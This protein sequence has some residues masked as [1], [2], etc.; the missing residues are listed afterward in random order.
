MDILPCYKRWGKCTRFLY[1]KYII[2]VK[3]S[4][5][6]CNNKFERIAPIE[7]G[8]I[9][10]STNTPEYGNS[11]AGTGVTI[12]L[13]NLS[14]G[15]TIHDLFVYIYYIYGYVEQCFESKTF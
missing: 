3:I 2:S 4:A 11:E 14:G 13:W 15:I 9:E 1:C 10:L 12:D 8:V 6:Y 7:L 5:C